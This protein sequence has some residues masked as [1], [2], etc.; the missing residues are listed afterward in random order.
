MGRNSYFVMVM[1]DY[2]LWIMQGK[3]SMSDN[4]Q[5]SIMQKRVIFDSNRLYNQIT[6][7]IDFLNL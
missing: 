7:Q 1:S 6:C 2:K 5:V 4:N 3:S